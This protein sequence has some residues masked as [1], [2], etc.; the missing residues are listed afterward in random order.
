VW[1][2][3]FI[4]CVPNYQTLRD[5]QKNAQRVPGI[6]SFWGDYGAI[7]LRLS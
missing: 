3:E 6:F 4:A 1:G 5:D 7:Y 2:R